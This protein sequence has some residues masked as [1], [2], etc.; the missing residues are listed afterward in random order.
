MPDRRENLVE[1]KDDMS[2]PTAV[3]NEAPFNHL[4]NLKMSV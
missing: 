3:P 1:C 2:Q 4:L